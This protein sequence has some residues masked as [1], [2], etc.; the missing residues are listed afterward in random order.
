MSTETQY[1][2]I[3]IS[4]KSGEYTMFK[5]Y[6]VGNKHQAI[7]DTNKLRNEYPKPNHIVRRLYSTVT[8]YKKL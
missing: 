2:P 6:F 4:L 8:V 7:K 5:Q 1:I 3:D